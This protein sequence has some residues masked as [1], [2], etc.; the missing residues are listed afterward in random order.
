MA[1]AGLIVDIVR[2]NSAGVDQTEFY[3]G[4]VDTFGIAAFRAFG[5]AVIKAT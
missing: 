3:R 2:L 4:T 5:F 1:I